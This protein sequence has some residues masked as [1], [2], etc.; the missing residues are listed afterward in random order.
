MKKQTVLV[1]ILI[2]F[3]YS[4]ENNGQNVKSDAESGCKLLIINIILVRDK[5][6]LI[7]FGLFRFKITRVQSDGVFPFSKLGLFFYLF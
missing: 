2:F 1:Y 5:P 7:I 4:D 6:L 3:P